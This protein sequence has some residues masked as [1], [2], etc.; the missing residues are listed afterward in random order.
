LIEFIVF[1]IL[2]LFFVILFSLI[3]YYILLFK[4]EHRNEFSRDEL[5]DFQKLVPKSILDIFEMNGNL[6][7]SIIVYSIFMVIT[8]LFSLLG[9]IV[10]SPH[11]TNEIGNYFFLLPILFLLICFGYSFL[12]SQLFPDLEYNHHSFIRNLI[13]QES[14]LILSTGISCISMNF[15]VYG[16]YQQI[17]FLFVLFNFILIF[18]ILIWKL[19]KPNII[20]ENYETEGEYYSEP[21]WENDQMMA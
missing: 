21:D 19:C 7:N 10:G 17:S 16:V 12:V 2:N 11:Y 1:L 3:R 9:G 18:G 4:E 13:Y 15:A 6:P 14:S 20:E 8:Y 5:V